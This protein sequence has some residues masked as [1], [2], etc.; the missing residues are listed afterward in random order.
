[1]NNA[2]R[3]GR[4]TITKFLPAKSSSTRSSSAH[5]YPNGIPGGYKMVTTKEGETPRLYIEDNLPIAFYN[6]PAKEVKAIFSTNN[7][8][9]PTR[10]LSQILPARQIDLW[11]AEELQERANGIRKKHW[12]LMK[13]MPELQFWED[14]YDY[15]DCY[16]IYFQGAMNLWN[17]MLHLYHENQCL[18][19]NLHQALTVEVGIWC[20]EWA[21]K[22]ENKKKLLDFKHWHGNFIDLL[23]AEDR[24]ELQ[25]MPPFN[26]ELV[27]TA[28]NY[29]HDQLLGKSWA[30]PT[31][32]PQNSL[33]FQWEEG[34]LQHWL[35]GQPVQDT[36]SGLAPALTASNLT[37]GDPDS[38]LS[39]PSL[40]AKNAPPKPLIVSGTYGQNPVD[41]IHRGHTATS[42]S[43]N[44][45]EG[46]SVDNRPT[47]PKSL[48]SISDE[49]RH[50]P[51][52]MRPAFA[53]SSQPPMPRDGNADPGGPI[54]NPHTIRSDGH[55]FNMPFT[56][57]PRGVPRPYLGPVGPPCGLLGLHNAPLGP[58]AGS[59]NRQSFPPSQ[60][61]PSPQRP[62]DNRFNNAGQ[63]AQT[64][65]PVF[66][67][68]AHS[69]QSAA[70][71]GG[72]AEPVPFQRHSGRRNASTNP[73]FGPAG[74]CGPPMGPPQYD[75]GPSLR[76]APHSNGLEQYQQ[77]PRGESK[78]WEKVH[79]AD[80]SIHGP[81][82]RRSPTKES[83]PRE[84]SRSSGPRQIVS[85]TNQH[86][87][88]GDRWAYTP[89]ECHSCEKRER[90]VFIE[91]TSALAGI[92]EDDLCE[93][94]KAIMSRWGHVERVG[95]LPNKEQ[96]DHHSFFVRFRDDSR[97]TEMVSADGFECAEFRCLLNIKPVHH[98]RY[99]SLMHSDFVRR[100]NDRRE[101][102]S[103]REGSQQS[104][105]RGNQN[106][107]GQGQPA[108]AHRDPRSQV[109]L[110]QYIITRP[111]RQQGR[112]AQGSQSTAVPDKSVSMPSAGQV[113]LQEKAELPEDTKQKQTKMTEEIALQ[114]SAETQSQSKPPYEEV[115]P[116]EKKV[117][118]STSPQIADSPNTASSKS[119]VVNL[120]AT[121]QKKQKART[122][123][124]EPEETDSSNNAVLT[125]EDGEAVASPVKKGSPDSISGKETSET[126]CDQR[127][128]EVSKN[129][130][131][132]VAPVPGEDVPVPEPLPQSPT[133]GKGKYRKV[134]SHRDASSVEVF[135]VVPYMPGRSN[136]LLNKTSS[137]GERFDEPSESLR[138]HSGHTLDSLIDAGLLPG[139][140]VTMLAGDSLKKKSK[141]SKKKKKK[142][143]SE[144]QD[145]THPTSDASTTTADDKVPHVPK[146]APAGTTEMTDII[147]KAKDIVATE[148]SVEKSSLLEPAAK[149]FRANAGGSLR[150]PKNR[151]KQPTQLNLAPREVSASEGA[152]GL[153]EPRVFDGGLPSTASTSQMSFITAQESRSSN[154][155]PRMQST[156]PTPPSAETPE[157][158]ATPMKPTIES[159][160]TA[161]TIVLLNPKAKEFI[162]PASR[163]VAHRVKLA[164]IPLVPI[165]VKTTQ[166]YRNSSRSSS[167]TSRTI[168]PGPTPPRNR[169]EEC[170]EGVTGNSVDKGQDPAIHVSPTRNNGAQQPALEEA[171]KA[172]NDP[173]AEGA[174]SVSQEASAVSNSNGYLKRQQKG[175][176]KKKLR[177]P[178]IDSQQYGQQ[179]Q[180]KQE[181]EKSHP[182]PK[183]QKFRG[184]D[185]RNVSGAN[186]KTISVVSKDEFPSLPAAPLPAPGLPASSVWGKAHAISTAATTIPSTS[187]LGVQDETSGNPRHQENGGKH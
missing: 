138:I 169:A 90:S 72:A 10:G 167:A 26:M 82:F 32:Y 65:N 16:D 161:K 55:A 163:P 39:Q 54:F 160:A 73:H 115:I 6:Q 101:I 123:I 15:F 17:L 159:E 148:A 19:R 4:G 62:I 5:Y 153:K 11:S 116:D 147:A 121:P 185:D 68:G 166:H 158:K 88:F 52:H 74:E 102:A 128:S 99:G 122:D 93:K 79:N 109:S 89:C 51:G 112:A 131:S 46:S 151:K 80:D 91:F 63:V 40:A 177:Q 183:K 1:M 87:K 41:A 22:S 94:V 69:F 139:V 25:G 30:R 75:A 76:G 12:S 162:S 29:R 157:S 56:A 149:S 129:I 165:L 49:P 105:W 137:T 141:R 113:A 37:M 71:L 100:A 61:T 86:E 23:S 84:L 142:P 135:D 38:P 53:Q 176:S 126:Q 111:Q 120:P 18:L 125:P 164:P 31:S 81:V 132:D 42:N 24:V 156:P 184:H 182:S 106:S 186:S 67:G 92:S 34:T 103:H 146:A 170:Q 173:L 152:N 14:L 95:H 144:I 70:Y 43:S 127:E 59:G 13:S 154:S 27:R 35:A 50:L 78:G 117:I 178:S 114:R 77:R 150:L 181:P 134:F 118:E 2:D 7:G 57:G 171:E 48:G 124:E 66:S 104:P 20:D 8:E 33:G 58:P 28:L 133:Y 172:E 130:V 187:N 168:T 155:S 143:T 36:P 9:F 179:R 83:S 136:S 97:L 96:G 85:C 60:I 21:A 140:S 108:P 44:Y 175:T 47:S 110:E 107:F 3:D 98:T 45:P 145:E 174:T 64:T 119:I 180:G